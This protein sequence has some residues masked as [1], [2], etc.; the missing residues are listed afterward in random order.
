MNFLNKIGFVMIVKKD[1]EF[2]KNYDIK[3]NYF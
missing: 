2:L 3:Y 1:M